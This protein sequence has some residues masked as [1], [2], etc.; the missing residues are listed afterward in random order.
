MASSHDGFELSMMDMRMRG[1]GDALGFRQSGVP[2]FILGDI[3]KDEKILYQAKIDAK[4]ISEDKENPEY[5]AII[6]S[7]LS[8]DYF[9][10]T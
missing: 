4:H 9:K 2:N 8:Q 1:I 10:T 6:N 5:K 7:V 3:E